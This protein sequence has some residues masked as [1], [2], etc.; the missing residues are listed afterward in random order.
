MATIRRKKAA[1][2][3]IR[4][5]RPVQESM[6]SRQRS[7]SQPQGRSRAKPGSTGGGE[8]FHIEIR[9]KTEFKRF[10]TQDV[11]KRG[12]IERVAGKRSSGSWNTQK[13]LISKEHA[14]VER[15]KLVPDTADARKVLR[16]LGTTPKHLRGDRFKA[17]D[18]PNVPERSKPTAAQRRARTTNIR[19]A[20]AANQRG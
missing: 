16:T 19:K 8:F 5:A 1:S 20:R 18:R 11:G 14:H 17:A 3:N 6:T 4:K 2:R 12:G 10:R 7:R 15:G 9:P 13:W